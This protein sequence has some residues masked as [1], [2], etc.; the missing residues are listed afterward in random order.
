MP[1]KN[2]IRHKLHKKQIRA[3]AASKSKAG[4]KRILNQKGGALLLFLL[5]PAL[6]LLATI[7]AGKIAK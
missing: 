4:V 7:V 1:P 6:S 2:L 3:L 5:N